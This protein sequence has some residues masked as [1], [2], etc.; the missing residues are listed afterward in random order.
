MSI[1]SS[2]VG[3]RSPDYRYQ[4]DA[5][6]LMAYAAGVGD[7][8]PCYFD[9]T[10]EI[11]PHPLFPVCLE[12]DPI[13]AVRNGPGSGS[14]SP[15]EKAR[16]VHAEHDLHW[17]HPLRA[18]MELVT[19]A[20]AIGLEQRPPGAYL[21]K[22]IDTFDT[23][24]TLICQTYQGNLYRGVAVSGG[25]ICHEPCP[26]L[27]A[28][29]PPAALSIQATLNVPTNAAHLYTECARIW[30][31][32]HTD[33]AAALAA[34]LPDI[35]LHGTATLAYAISSLIAQHVAR[36]PSAVYRL[37]GR[38]SGMVRLPDALVVESSVT[39]PGTLHF[40]VVNAA[41][42]EV[43]RRGFLCYRED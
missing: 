22:R 31:P 42:L 12:W 30:N 15:E 35:I 25:P 17:H 29:P 11:V 20:T 10:G 33:K 27:P 2:I 8:A 3:V 41:G 34:G 23:E 40:R 38:F 39:A 13:L 7:F 9:T 32:I 43:I 14:V 6:W 24:G 37:G 18:G 5:R 4:V 21:T 26:A 36:G 1:P 16:A 28:P 19:R